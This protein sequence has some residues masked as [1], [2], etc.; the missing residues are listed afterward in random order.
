[1]TRLVTAAFVILAACG[2]KQAAVEQPNSSN[3]GAGSGRAILAKKISISWGIQPEGEMADVFLQTTDE[4]GKQVSHPAGRYKGKC[5]VITPAPEMNAIS[6]VACTTGG[7]GTEL[8]AVKKG[9]E[10]LV[11]QMGTQPGQ[12]P[13]PMAREQVAIVKIPVGVAVEGAQ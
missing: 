9:D 8:H 12:K 5:E 13:D 10:I 7:G 3:G 11:V 4:V 6:G 1:M 2:G